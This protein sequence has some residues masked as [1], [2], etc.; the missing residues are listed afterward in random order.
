MWL[1]K[2]VA[3]ALIIFTISVVGFLVLELVSQ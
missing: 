1:K 3:I 2:T